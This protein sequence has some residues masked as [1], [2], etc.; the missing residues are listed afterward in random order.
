MIKRITMNNLFGRFCYDITLK[1]GGVTIITG[2]NGFGKSTILK[3]IDAL[4]S[5]N[6]YFF[7]KIDF[8]NIKIEFDN[9][10]VFN[11]VRNNNNSISYDGINLNYDELINEETFYDD[12]RVFTRYITKQSKDYYIDRRNGTK[13]PKDELIQL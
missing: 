10:K 4:S 12:Y 7:Y 6:F 1:D 8:N 2:P 3:V 11:V 9:G 5:M 13:I